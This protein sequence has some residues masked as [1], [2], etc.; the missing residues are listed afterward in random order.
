M[1]PI[2]RD[3]LV[4]ALRIEVT[5][6]LD[7]PGPPDPA[8]TFASSG[9]RPMT[10]SEACLIEAMMIGPESI[11]V[12]S[13][14]K[15]TVAHRIGAIVAV[16]SVVDALQVEPPWRCGHTGLAAR[17]PV[18]QPQ[19]GRRLSLEHCSDKRSDHM[20]E[21]RARSNREVE[22]IASALPSGGVN[23]AREH[24]VLGL[25]RRECSEV[26]LARE[27]GRAGR[28][29]A[30]FERTRPPERPPSLER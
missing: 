5:H 27:R 19:E 21:K 13:R 30:L 8:R 16:G 12:P 9:S 24:R 20:T 22:M 15:R 4:Y 14:S 18:E 28:Q 2:D 25:R 17:P 10:V 7:E 1:R 6:L 11:S 29:P 26:V 3:E 23:T